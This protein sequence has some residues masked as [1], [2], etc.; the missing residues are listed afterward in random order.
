MRS[1]NAASKLVDLSESEFVGT[2]H[3]D[4][5][6]IGNVDAGFNDGGADQ[7]IGSLVIK[8][9]HDLLELFFAHLTMADKDSRGW[10]QL[11]EFIGDPFDVFHLIVKVI[12][13]TAA[14]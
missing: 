4:G 7:N 1:A 11:L 10:H 2:I 3:D 5:I 14:Q 13:L 12:H 6:G 8:I 9:R